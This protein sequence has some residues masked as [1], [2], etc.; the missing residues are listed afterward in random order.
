[1]NARIESL[2]DLVDQ[3]YNRHAWHG[4][5]LRGSLRGLSWEQASWRPGKKRHNIWEI[6]V[7]AAYWKFCIRRHLTGRRDATFPREG[8][9]WFT[10]PQ[11]DSAGDSAKRYKRD[12]ALLDSEHKLLREALAGFSASR[13]DRT[14]EGLKY[15]YQQYV[16]GIASHDL[17]HAGQ[18]QLLKRLLK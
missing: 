6:V 2:L 11:G 17:Y 4:T 15:T 12:V 14:P 13:L 1:M 9:N 10:L 3:A 5:N 16:H 7:H 18:I 8:S